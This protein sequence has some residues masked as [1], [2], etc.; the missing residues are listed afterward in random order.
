MTDRIN[1]LIVTLGKDMRDDDVQRLVDAIKLM[2]NVISVKKNVSNG[3]AHI[4]FERA[5]HELGEK[6]WNVLHP[7]TETNVT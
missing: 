2:R 5:R 7:E 1:A 6:L 3:A 4:A